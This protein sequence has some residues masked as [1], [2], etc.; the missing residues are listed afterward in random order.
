[1]SIDEAL[2]YYER[3]VSAGSYGDALVGA[4]REEVAA[5]RQRAEQAEK[6][7]DEW[8]TKAMDVETHPVVVA[9]KQERGCAEADNAALLARLQAVCDAAMRSDWMGPNGE[10]EARFPWDEIEF[11]LRDLHADHP[12][13]ALL[14]RLRALEAVRDAAISF[15]HAETS[16]EEERLALR[17]AC[18][19]ADALKVRP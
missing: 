2:G 3:H 16:S 6:E 15:A 9:L 10:R 5:L 19:A 7:R 13:A 14:E 12:G 1:M 17:A 11:S 4:A 8:R 18:V